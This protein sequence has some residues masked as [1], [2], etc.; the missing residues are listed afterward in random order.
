MPRKRK[1]VPAVPPSPEDVEYIA[2][3][4]TSPID[5]IL[6]HIGLRF[7]ETNADKPA[8]VRAVRNALRLADRILHRTR[9]EDGFADT[10]AAQCEFEDSL[11][12]QAVHHEPRL[13]LRYF[14]RG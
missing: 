8:A 1:S 9:A 13:S 3:L 7:I 12:M 4:R 5:S 11:I 6:R 2:S 14:I 10:C